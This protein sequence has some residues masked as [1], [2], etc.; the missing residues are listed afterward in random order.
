MD[1]IELAQV[2]FRKIGGRWS[3]GGDGIS[4]DH[5]AATNEKDRLYRHAGAD[6]P[7]AGVEKIMLGEPPARERAGG[8]SRSACGRRWHAWFLRG[9][10]RLGRCRHRCGSRTGRIS[11]QCRGGTDAQAYHERTAKVHGDFF[12][13]KRWGAKAVR[14]PRLFREASPNTNNTPSPIQNHPPPGAPGLARRPSLRNSQPSMR[15]RTMLRAKAKDSGRA[16]A[17]PKQPQVMSRWRNK[18]ETTAPV[19][20][21]VIASN[22]INALRRK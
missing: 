9:S 7:F 16:L 18:A 6:I 22:K 17:A 10:E 21:T 19:K 12:R 5:L 11:F 8:R 15:R 3:L 2:A 4:P 20:M 1:V 13:S 14:S